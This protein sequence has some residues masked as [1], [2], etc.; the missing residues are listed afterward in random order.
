[1]KILVAAFVL[2]GLTACFNTD[3]SKP[4]PPAPLPIPSIWEAVSDN[5][6]DNLFRAPAEGGWV[7]LYSG[8]RSVGMV[9]V[10]NAPINE[11]R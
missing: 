1:M 8:F 11:C 2:F 4:P 10:P 7:Y 9:F 3:P 5:R 6:N